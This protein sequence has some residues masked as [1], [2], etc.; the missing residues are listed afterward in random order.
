MPTN[1]LNMKQNLKQF[2]K[3]NI[4]L[5]PLKS[6]SLALFFSLSLLA[7]NLIF[8]PTSS[9][10]A[11]ATFT[12]TST[13]DTGAGSLRQAILDANSN[14]N[15]SDQDIINF[16]IPGTGDHTIYPQSQLTIT[17]SVLV[18]GYTQPGAEANT[19]LAPLALDGTL[20][21]AID[22]S[23]N[24]GG[25]LVQSDNVTLSGLSIY[26]STEGEIKVEDSV[27]FK[28][29]G[30]YI[31][32]DVSGLLMH[33]NYS[34]TGNTP[35]L[36]LSGT[37]NAQIGGSSP[38]QRN[39]FGFNAKSYVEAEASNSTQTTG[40]K[41][42]G[43]NIGVGSDS[44][45]YELGGGGGGTGIVI[46]GGSNITV[47]GEA[48]GAGNSILNLGKGAAFIYDVDDL[49]FFGNIV[50]N[51]EGTVNYNSHTSAATIFFA[52][53]T[54]SHIG[55]T[56]G[57]GKNN[58]SG[59]QWARGIHIGDSPISSNPSNN[60]YVEGNTFGYDYTETESYPNEAGNILVNGDSDGIMIRSN[61]IHNAVTLHN[62]TPQGYESGIAITDN[63]QNV[64]ILQ[65]SIYNNNGLGIDLAADNF[66]NPNDA[67]DTD[68]GPNTM[69]NGPLTTNITE[70][71]GDTVVSFA[72]DVPAGNYRIEFFSNT[73][74]DP[75][76]A[77]EGETFLGYKEITSAGTGTEIFE[78]NLSGTSI[79]NL[80]MTATL[81]D[82]NSPTGFG[83]TSEFGGEG[84][85]S[86]ASDTAISK[87]LLNPEDVQ[88]NGILNYEVS[89]TNY[90]PEDVDLAHWNGSSMGQNNLFLDFMPPQ[91]T[92]VGVSSPDN[93]T[94]CNYL[95]D[96]SGAYIGPTMANHT[97]YGAAFCSYTGPSQILEAG[98]SYKV[99]LSARV[100]DDSSLEFINYIS[101]PP[102][103][104]DPDYT[105][106]AN[107]AQ[108][109]EDLLD[110]LVGNTSNNN[111]GYAYSQVA[112]TQTTK[113]LTTDPADIKD[114]STVEYTIEYKNNGPSS[115]D[116][117]QF[118][119][120]GQNPLVTGLFIDFLPPNLSY[121]SQ[122]NPD[123]SCTWVNQPQDLA[124]LR[125]YIIPAHQDYTAMFCAYTGSDSELT[126]GESISTTLTTQVGTVGQGFTNYAYGNSTIA[127]S[128][129]R[130]IGNSG[131]PGSGEDFIDNLKKYNPNNFTQSVYQVEQEQGGSENGGQNGGSQNPTGGSS[132]NGSNPNRTGSSASSN[133]GSGLSSTGQ[134]ILLV[135]VLAISLIGGAGYLQIKK[136][137]NIQ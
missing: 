19:A 91:L 118:D 128:D 92:Y 123:L 54:N 4:K 109:G 68:G 122:S 120:S 37:T 63:A 89:F 45:T 106:Y 65:N 49:D 88:L 27:N 62:P 51:S 52:G 44:L 31:S 112:D 105:N 10:A 77:G 1:K 43:N 81:I 39:V 46:K 82:P 98:Q 104:L 135:L 129:T 103:Q 133:S 121:V 7:I 71:G 11:P 30:S 99:T 69:L 56:T 55:S 102:A 29:Y 22:N 3:Q 33:R 66:A 5:K 134:N 93:N 101:S 132:S 50:Q 34:N 6:I 15:P 13:N 17:E 32:T 59:T 136:K 9:Y 74:P 36:F 70:S 42:Q 16:S 53:I 38:E 21:V 127:D 90:G 14:N 113:T 130:V 111:F 126:A 23:N 12:V 67:N 25:L 40:L 124:A 110:D 78:H 64:S 108:S 57:F 2:S 80:A 26:Y 87:K 114:G 72:L 8:T 100:K 47:G 20:R 85:V 86:K 96:G 117:R 18:D 76:G 84:I 41:I 131:K 107:S 116:P 60:V 115:I 24:S 75:S 58:I 125:Q 95:G 83:P 79:P 94:S 35:A 137:K 119:G 28:L 97:D 73:E 61:K 48:E